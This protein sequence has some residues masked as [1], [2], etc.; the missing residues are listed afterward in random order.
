MFICIS[1]GRSRLAR[2]LERAVPNNVLCIL[3][4]RDSSSVGDAMVLIGRR[5]KSERHKHLMSAFWASLAI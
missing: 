5:N 2:R 3:I 1:R 4:Q